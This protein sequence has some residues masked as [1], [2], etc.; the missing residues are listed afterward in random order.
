MDQHVQMQISEGL[1]KRGVDV[2]TAYE[3]GHSET[4]DEDLLVRATKLQRILFSEDSDFLI[5]GNRWQQDRHN[6]A[7]IIYAHQLNITIGQAV[8]DLK[9]MAEVL[10]PE[11]MRNKV[12]F[13][14]L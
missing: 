6:F 7:G 10:E 4:E 2:L 11:D 8:R 1:R 12:E 9:L 13:I 5:I 3:D 14:P